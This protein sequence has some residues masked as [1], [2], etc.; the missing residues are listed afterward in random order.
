MTVPKTLSSIVRHAYEQTK[1]NRIPW[2]SGATPQQF[3]F[4]LGEQSVVVESTSV[5]RRDNPL[6][7]GLYSSAVPAIRFR[8]LNGEGSEIE[9]FTIADG[10]GDFNQ[11]HEMWEYARQTAKGTRQDIEELDRRLRDLSNAANT[12]PPEPQ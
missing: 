8:I 10:D 3:V 6:L 11:L 5:Q 9:V 1:R 12:A 2:R 7:G 4:S